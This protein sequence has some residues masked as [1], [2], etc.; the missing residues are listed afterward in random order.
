MNC[1]YPTSVVIF[2]SLF[3]FY[4][5]FDVLIALLSEISVKFCGIVFEVGNLMLLSVYS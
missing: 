1:C 3:T 2:L 5:L 4:L